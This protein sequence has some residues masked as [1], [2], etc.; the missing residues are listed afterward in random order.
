MEVQNIPPNKLKE[1]KEEKDF[2]RKYVQE[3]LKRDKDMQ[4]SSV[5]RENSSKAYLHG[6]GC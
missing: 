1:I 3:N 2:F 5:K 6:N 4:T